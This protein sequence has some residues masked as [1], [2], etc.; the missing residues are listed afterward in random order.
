M[1][2]DPLIERLQKLDTCALSDA[3]DRLKLP[4]V[5]L[6]MGP[7]WNCLRV[8]GR[9]VT[10]KL[11]RVTGNETA[12]RHLGTAAVVAAN[13]GDVIVVEHHD[14]ADCAGWGGILANAAVTKGVAGVIVDGSA[15]D[16]DETRDVGLPLYARAAVPTTARGRVVEASTNEPIN[17]GDVPVSPGD[18]VLVD[19]SGAVFLPADRAEEIITTAEELAAREALMT[20]DVRA[21][22]PVTEVMGTNYETM[23]QQR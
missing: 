13:P 9:I 16:I 22:K 3:L 5:V 7:M 12:T 23:L 1:S 19:W 21:G 15:R 20:T 14:R 10:V 8:A 11:V 4:G 18:V 2:T 6:G 17:V